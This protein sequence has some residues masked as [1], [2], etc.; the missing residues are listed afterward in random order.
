M[1]QPHVLFYW[2][3]FWELCSDRPPGM[4]STSRIPFTA[5]D[6]FARRYGIHDLDAF[7]RFRSIIR[8]MDEAYCAGPSGA[9]GNAVTDPNGRGIAGLLRR[10]AKKSRGEETPEESADHEES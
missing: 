9:S 4:A 8:E 10:M 1:L 2:N 5:I 6:R 3:A 7:D